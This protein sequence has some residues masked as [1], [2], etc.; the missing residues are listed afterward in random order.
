[1]IKKVISC[2]LSSLML[3]GTAS[4]ISIDTDNT[5]YDFDTKVSHIE[6]TS[7]Y[8]NQPV[9]LEIL[10]KNISFGSDTSFDDVLYMN[11]VRSDE[12]KEFSFDVLLDDIG[13]FSY[14]V[15]ELSSD[16][17]CLS[18]VFTYTDETVNDAINTYIENA[19]RT[20]EELEDLIM[21][22][23]PGLNI[24]ITYY[25]NLGE[26]SR[27]TL[28]SK[29][30]SKEFDD[31]EEFKTSVVNDIATAV[32]FSAQDTS[33]KVLLVQKFANELEIA[34]TKCYTDYLLLDDEEKKS[35]VSLLSDEDSSVFAETFKNEFV[36]YRVN[37]AVWN[38]V[39]EIMDKYLDCGAEALFKN[40]SNDNKK[41]AITA[42]KIA[43]KD[44]N[45]TKAEDMYNY[46]KKSIPKDQPGGS[47]GMG[48]SGGAGG[49]G[50][51]FGAPAPQV[52]APVVI[53][54]S[55]TSTDTAGKG[56][57]TD[58]QNVPWAEEAVS[59]LYKKGVING[60]ADKTFAPDD[61]VT[62]EEFVKMIMIAFKYDNSSA[63]CPFGDVQKNSWYY[64]YV[65]SAYKLNIISGESAE[66]FGTGHNIKRQDMAVILYNILKNAYTI[67]DADDVQKFTDN[68]EI[69][70]YAKDAVNALSAMGC[71]NGDENGNVMPHKN[72]TRAEAAK[73]IYSVLM[74][75]KE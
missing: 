63:E 8:K 58:L 36:L 24:D 17:V 26:E 25:Q 75:V 74:A 45:I 23:Y 69:S 72:S 48:G 46:L 1:M 19:D 56:Y 47:G 31:V 43:V 39:P 4:A 5:S 11:Q 41:A 68:G 27:E 7:T 73:I 2:I 15:S 38:I 59:Y 54:D 37:T 32:V 44:G 61:S 13:I 9:K 49:S 30:N 34:G 6:G 53:T 51:N 64:P 52:T 62:R 40:V 12:N 42:L 22:Y 70:D 55:N 14:R 57:F 18:Q 65:C 60:K 20:T 67:A 50:G 10:K 29:I 33:N 35:F 28:L 66:T 16:N 3:F 71:L 21:D